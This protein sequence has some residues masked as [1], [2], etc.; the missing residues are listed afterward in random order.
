MNLC[1]E[2]KT[3]IKGKAHSS[4]ATNATAQHSTAQKQWRDT[5]VRRHTMS[6]LTFLRWRTGL[7]LLNEPEY[8]PR[9]D[10]HL[11]D[12]LHSLHEEQRKPQLGQ[13]QQSYN[14]KDGLQPQHLYT[15]RRIL[16]EK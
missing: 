8:A 3:K 13:I 14:I 4:N 10:Q 7:Q 6:T 12:T 15:D 9:C 2:T 5:E 16:Y 1:P 11:T